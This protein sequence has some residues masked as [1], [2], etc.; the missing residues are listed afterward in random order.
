MEK[1]VETNIYNSIRET[2]MVARKKV[3]TTAN[4]VMVEAYW[5]IGKQIVDAQDNN[6]RA[7]YGS[8]LLKF[9]SEK[10]AKEFGKG[11]DERNLRFM[12]QF[13]QTF[14]IRNTLC[15]ELSWSHY[16]RLMKIVDENRREFYMQESVDAGWSVR[17]LERQINSFY[18]E[19]LLATGTSNRD[20][21]RNEIQAHEPNTNPDFILKD[22]YILKI[23]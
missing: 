3:Y 10:L 6:P 19:R 18:Y 8:Q 7:E 4:F 20:E 21:I 22:P 16:R 13:Y 9:L 11:F 5:N 23:K 14:P 17:Q 12:R 2:L 1:M 15:S